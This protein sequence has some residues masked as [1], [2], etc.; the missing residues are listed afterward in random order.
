MAAL[1]LLPGGN[2]E[3]PINKEIQKVRALPMQNARN[4]AFDMVEVIATF[5][6]L[7]GFYTIFR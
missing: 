2:L 5:F 6:I 3:I 7:S 4:H 1:A